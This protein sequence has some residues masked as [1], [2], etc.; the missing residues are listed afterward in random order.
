LKGRVVWITGASS[1]LGE[2]LAIRAAEDGVEGLILSGRRE[3]AL[4]KVRRACVAVSPS[5]SDAA[6]RVLPFDMGDLDGITTQP[7]KALGEFGRVDVLV[8]NAGVSFWEETSMDV[9]KQVMAV[10][11]LGCVGLVKGVLGPMLNAGLGQ[12]VVI[13]S[14]QGKFG[15]PFRA[16]YAASKHALVGFSDTLRAEVANRGVGVTSVFPGYIRTR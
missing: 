3:D 5:R 15:I 1:G 4:E 13:N 2:Q 8:L 6:V 9:D 16:S 10:N 11:Y 7:A 12:F 14:V